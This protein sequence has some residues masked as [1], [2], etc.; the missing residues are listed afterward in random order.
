MIKK[1]TEIKNVGKFKNYSSSELAFAKFSAIYAPNGHGKS[2]IT[3]I[4]RSMGDANPALII[5]R[6]S[7]DAEAAPTVKIETDTGFVTFDGQKWSASDVQF[8]IFD[9]HFINQ[10]IFSGMQVDLA[11]RKKLYQF[12]IGEAAIKFN[13]RVTLFNQEI[14]ST[15][16]EITKLRNKIERLSGEQIP[17]AS[18]ISLKPV[19]DVDTAIAEKEKEISALRNKDKILKTPIFKTLPV[20]KLNFSELSA[21]LTKTQEGLSTESEALVRQHISSLHET[22]SEGWL[23]YGNELLL[24][25][26]DHCPFCKAE[27]RDN[28]LIAAYKDFFNE[29]YKEFKLELGQLENTVQTAFSQQSFFSMKSVFEDGHQLQQQWEEY[30]PEIKTLSAGSLA[31]TAEAE[32]FFNKT[33]GDI[34]QAVQAKVRTPLDEV[35]STEKLAELENSYNLFLQKCLDFNTATAKQ[36]QLI[37]SYKSSLGSADLKTEE[38]NLIILNLVKIRF[39]EECSQLCEEYMELSK[40][41][42]S[43]DVEKN[44]ARKLLDTTTNSIP[45]VYQKHINN[46][47]EKFG[48][49]FRITDHR[50]INPRGEA[51]TEYKLSLKDFAIPLGDSSTPDDTPSFKNTLSEGDKSTLAFSYFLAKLNVEHENLKNKILVFDDPISSQDATR[52]AWT[53]TFLFEFGKRAKQIIILS[54]DAGFI[55][56]MVHK[57]K[58]VDFACLM[59]SSTPTTNV[60]EKTTVAQLSSNDAIRNLEKVKNYALYRIGVAEDTKARIRPLLEDYLRSESPRTFKA[61]DTLETMMAAVRESQDGTPLFKFKERLRDL[62]ALKNYSIDSSLQ[63]VGAKGLIDP[64]ELSTHC[65]QALSFI[66]EQSQP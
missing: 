9:A 44:K 11:Q 63:S 66:G 3:S 52:R 43:L 40:V 30:I 26:P 1:I 59:I 50:K 12:I 60:L 28:Q 51:A 45:Q 41:K 47:L 29:K 23:R 58:N 27:T 61:G 64:N 34:T 54:H 62:E 4:L 46:F 6:K 37:A 35:I 20:P 15:N 18:F 53:K 48:A 19:P 14:W 7:I 33:V 5:G 2:T 39:T 22:T 38:H 57:F 8:E 32:L 36:N 65:R 16:S 31:S 56:E 55:E 49:D 25:N 17:T 13:D 10:N 24:K 42:E 21:A